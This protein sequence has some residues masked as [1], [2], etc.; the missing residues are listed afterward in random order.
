MIKSF[1]IIISFI[2]MGYSYIADISVKSI[3]SKVER[4]IE[5]NEMSVQN[6]IVMNKEKQGRLH[7]K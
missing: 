4:V 7:V 2:V 1:I 3:L 6:P 5:K